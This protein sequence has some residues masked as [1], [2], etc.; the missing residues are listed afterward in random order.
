L[1]VGLSDPGMTSPA[2][3]LGDAKA[4]LLSS[5]V[6]LRECCREQP[7]V[8]FQALC[9]GSPQPFQGGRQGS[10]P[11]APKLRPAPSPF[12]LDALPA[13]DM[14]PDAM[15][16][17]E[18]LANSVD[19]DFSMLLFGKDGCVTGTDSTC[20]GGRHSPP[21]APRLRPAPSPRSL[22]DLPD[23]EMLPDAMKDE[24]FVVDSSDEDISMLL[25]GVDGCRTGTGVTYLVA[26]DIQRPRACHA[27]SLDEERAM[28]AGCSKEDAADYLLTSALET[29]QWLRGLSSCST[30]ASTPPPSLKHFEVEFDVPGECH[31]L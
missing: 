17:G 14:L 13:F 16:D 31:G 30:R 2:L 28:R 4:S 19:D 15:K 11:K 20:S 18:T 10:P 29:S 27:V 12:S 22:D 23:L 21:K 25:F 24:E 5:D 3:V 6:S 26:T 9:A 7:I 8:Q 1:S